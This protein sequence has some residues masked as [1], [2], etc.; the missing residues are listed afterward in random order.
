MGADGL[1]IEV[2]PDPN[3]ALSDADQQIDFKVAKALINEI[4]PLVEL[5]NKKLC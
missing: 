4:L 1:L 3:S 5:N 2:H